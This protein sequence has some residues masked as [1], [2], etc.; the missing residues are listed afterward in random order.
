[1]DPC[2]SRDNLSYSMGTLEGDKP[3][4]EF[5]FALALILLAGLFIIVV[6]VAI[7]VTAQI[8]RWMGV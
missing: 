7:G 2:S 6:G 5:K 3:M 8:L 1:M 4:S